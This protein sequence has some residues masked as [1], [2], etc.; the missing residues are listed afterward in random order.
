MCEIHDRARL[1]ELR[2]SVDLTAFLPLADT[3]GPEGLF[4]GDVWVAS[5]EE[6]VVGFVAVDGDEVTWL[7]VHPDYY[8]RGIGRRLFRHAVE[9]CGTTVTVECLA[10]N[11]PAVGLYT[12]EGFEAGEP[13]T[14]RFTG[15]EG[16]SATGVEMRLRKR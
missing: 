3:A 15:N 2:G 8:R 7:Y 10:G 11:T 16:F 5:V 9:R 12:S 14:G 13:R 4:A 6:R 1:D